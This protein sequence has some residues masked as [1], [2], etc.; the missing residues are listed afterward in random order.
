MLCGNFEK[1]IGII[2]Y[3]KYD[4]TPF[5]VVQYVQ[6]IPYLIKQ[7]LNLSIKYCQDVARREGGIII[8]LE[9]VKDLFGG[10]ARKG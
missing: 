7:R 6:K 8:E 3:N 5:S 1:N 10:C 2:G 4:I 9:F